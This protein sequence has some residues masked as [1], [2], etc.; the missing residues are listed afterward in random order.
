MKTAAD[1]EQAFSVYFTEMEGCEIAECYWA[2]L[3]LAVVMP[4]V[5][6]A[7]EFGSTAKVGTR[8]MDW[9][10]ANFPQSSTLTPADSYQIRCALLHEGSTLTGGGS[11]QY[12]S[13]SFVDP[14]ATDADVHLLVT[15]DGKNIAID[16]K[17]LADE[18]RTAVRGWFGAVEKDAARNAAV[19]QNLPKLARRQTKVSEFHI[20]TEDGH[21]IVTEDSSALTG[22]LRYPT[23]SST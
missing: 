17:A 21:R 1:L 19:E 22:T 10:A 20:V 4:D 3:H 2:L 9:C 18:T 23:T 6:G 11:T 5:C 8:Y 15:P 16:I 13:F 7:L 12:S 14:V